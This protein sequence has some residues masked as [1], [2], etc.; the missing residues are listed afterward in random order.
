MKIFIFPI[1]QLRYVP[2][3]CWIREGE[4]RSVQVQFWKAKLWNPVVTWE[5]ISLWME[6][7]PQYSGW[8]TQND[9]CKSKMQ[10]SNLF[11]K[12][13]KK[14]KIQT[15]TKQYVFDR[16]I[17]ILFILQNSLILWKNNV[18]IYFLKIFLHSQHFE[19]MKIVTLTT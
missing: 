3:R 7:P 1:S 6:K 4:T 13:K 5:D 14:H 11:A 12:Q 2:R 19:T 18:W 17:E 15:S 16:E 8:Y 9:N 10:T